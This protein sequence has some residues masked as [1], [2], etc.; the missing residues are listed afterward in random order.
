MNVYT[1]NRKCINTDIY[2]SGSNSSKQRVIM[3]RERYYD[4]GMRKEDIQGGLGRVIMTQ[5]RVGR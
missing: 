5:S 3:N 4:F 2:M 1:Y